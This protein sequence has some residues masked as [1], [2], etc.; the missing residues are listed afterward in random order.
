MYVYLTEI[1][2]SVNHLADNRLNYLPIAYCVTKKNY[3][4]K[5]IMWSVLSWDFLE[6]EIRI[7]CS[8]VIPAL[9][10]EF[11]GIFFLSLVPRRYLYLMRN[12]YVI[13]TNSSSKVQYYSGSQTFLSQTKQHNICKRYIY[14]LILLL[15]NKYEEFYC[16]RYM[17]NSGHSF[18]L[19]CF[20]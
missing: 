16:P 5:F 6:Q 11:P 17:V 15:F 3:S 7:F 20:K 19:L 9:G 4:L 18:L 13:M 8:L 10:T 2:I 1:W 12:F 14:T